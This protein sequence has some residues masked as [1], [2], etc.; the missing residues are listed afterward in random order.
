MANATTQR[1]VETKAWHAVD[2]RQGWAAY[3][4]AVSFREWPA[5]SATV[6]AQPE[7]R[8]SYRPVL[9]ASGQGFKLR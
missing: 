8:E 9:L 4:A 3:Q 1:S 5:F 2:K 6:R 7:E